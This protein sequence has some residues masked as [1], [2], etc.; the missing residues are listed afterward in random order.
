MSDNKSDKIFT[1]AIDTLGSETKVKDILKGINQS[2]LRNINFNFLL[3]G[4][5]NEI[6]INLNK[7][8]K[9]EGAVKIIDCKKSIS[10]ND[11]PS[12]I[13]K[14]K[15]ESSMHLAV[16]AVKDKIADAVLSFGNTGALM[17]IS[18]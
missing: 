1:L 4:D 11:K 9:L 2:Y 16:N 14:S 7:Y 13:I 15:K 10:M 17:S 8:P 6:E 18:L 5:R 3:F 12:D